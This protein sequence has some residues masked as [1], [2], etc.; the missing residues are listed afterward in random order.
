[1]EVKNIDKRAKAKLKVQKE[2]RDKAAGSKK[3]ED[4]R[5]KQELE[6]TQDQHIVSTLIPPYSVSYH[7]HL[8]LTTH[9][10]LRML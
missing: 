5:K 3:D 10:A 4:K 8:K 6:V 9:I 7:P 1:M 2:E